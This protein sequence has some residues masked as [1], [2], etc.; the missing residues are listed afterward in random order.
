[1][2]FGPAFLYTF[3]A[4]ITQIIWR[5]VR[6]ILFTLFLGGIVLL[7][8]YGLKA[9]TATQIEGDYS[10]VSGSSF[11]FKGNSLEEIFKEVSVNEIDELDIKGQLSEADLGW[12]K[13]HRKSFISLQSLGI[14]DATT[15]IPAE[16][17]AGLPLLRD[18]A[19]HKSTALGTMAFYDCPSLEYVTAP[20]VT[21]LG[22]WSLANCPALQI[23]AFPELESIA[24]YAFAGCEQLNLLLGITP[25]SSVSAKA[26]DYC[27]SV[28][29][30]LLGNSNMS[31]SNEELQH[32]WDAYDQAAGG[33][34]WQ[35]FSYRNLYLLNN[36]T[37]YAGIGQ[38]TMH[39]PGSEVRLAVE[40]GYHMEGFVWYEGTREHP[41]GLAHPLELQD[42][43]YT[44]KMPQANIWL[45]GRR[46]PN[47]Y[48]VEFDANGGE[49]YMHGQELTYDKPAHLSACA[50]TRTDY[51]F[52][53][54]ALEPNAPKA[55]YDNVQMVSNLT[56]K[57]GAQ[58]TLYAIWKPQNELKEFSVTYGEKGATGGK[59]SVKTESAA[60]AAGDKV[61][62]G[63]LITTSIEIDSHTSLRCARLVA[64]MGDKSILLNVGDWLAVTD[65]VNL[66]A[67]FVSGAYSDKAV[68]HYKKAVH[69][70][71]IEITAD[72]FP[73]AEDD[74]VE[75]ATAIDIKLIPDNGYKPRAIIIN[76]LGVEGGVFRYTVRGTTHIAYCFERIESQKPD[77]NLTPVGQLLSTAQVVPNPFGDLLTVE[78]AADVLGYQLLNLQGM[79]VASGTHSGSQRLQIATESLPA[80]FYLLVLQSAEGSTTLRAV[81]R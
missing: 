57:S 40:P 58:I 49:G 41:I 65:D 36:S 11:D 21:S 29:Y 37:E 13:E 72:G 6:Q 25:P 2:T 54:W 63:Q 23:A 32:A 12:F 5:M 78:N 67:T 30:L 39:E 15:P 48:E 16:C 8:P 55:T 14:R 22:E 19:L 38:L 42:S 74:A 7:S 18:V 17:F 28:R 47:Q 60:V 59:L 51:A 3:A 73:I 10:L 81:K 45:E 75:Q 69:G 50:Y 35:G 52:I 76:G 70:G 77:P 66:T 46:T 31:M 62:E 24:D 26:F 53:G 34:N 80:G 61:A 27:P 33:A 1:M 20:K 68:L 71:R 56:P 9:Q 43:V 64:T 79:V 44:F 4:V